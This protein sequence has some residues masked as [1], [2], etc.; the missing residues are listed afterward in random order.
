M[1]TPYLLFLGDASEW[2]AAKTAAGILQWRPEWCLGQL[3]IGAGS[4][5]L[6]LPDL[7][8][9]QAAQ[10]GAGTLVI[11]IANA[12]GFI[13]DSWLP[14]LADA[15][16]QGLDLAAGM[17][18]RLADIPLLAQTAARLGRRLHDVR[19]PRRAFAPGN[20]LRR[21]GRRVLTVGTD[22]A[23]GKKYT[24]LAIERELRARGI[25]ADFRATGQTGILIAGD[26]VAVDAVIADFVSGAAEWLSPANAPDHWDVIEGQGGLMHP[27]YAGVTLGLIHGSQP[28]ALVI[29]HEPGR[30]HLAGFPHFP[31]PDLMQCLQANLAAARL[32]NPGVVAAGVS[33]NT[34]RLPAGEAMQAIAG[35]ERETGLPCCDPLRHGVGR[36]VD[37]LLSVAAQ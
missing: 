12:G 6:G 32:T 3:R 30:R 29:C 8:A 22:C 16:E 31:V 24:A 19:Q 17:H 11:G 37:H 15:L 28:D 18:T 26:G 9:A 33:V 21:S 35:L 1:R 23:I 5:D 10:Q 7:S 20:G 14:V 25:P 13:P 36:L 27:A 34:A 4:V 2:L